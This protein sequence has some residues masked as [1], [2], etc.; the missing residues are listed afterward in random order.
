MIPLDQVGL[1]GYSKNGLRKPT[2]TLIP[3]SSK[4]T[5]CGANCTFRW[6]ASNRRGVQKSSSTRCSE[7]ASQRS[8]RKKQIGSVA[9][10]WNMLCAS[11]TFRVNDKLALWEVRVNHRCDQ[12]GKRTKNAKLSAGSLNTERCLANALSSYC[13]AS[14]PFMQTELE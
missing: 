6:P 1:F 12:V 5:C 11:D 2:R 3:S 13:S 8:H 9:V 14:Y 7:A 10:Y 4:P